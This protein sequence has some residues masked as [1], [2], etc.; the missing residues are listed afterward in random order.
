ME[1]CPNSSYFEYRLFERKFTLDHI[2]LNCFDIM[3]CSVFF[4][5]FDV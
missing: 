2:I 3:I 4:L 1:E 5:N